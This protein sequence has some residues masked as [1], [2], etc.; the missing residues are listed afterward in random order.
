MLCRKLYCFVDC[1]FV[2]LGHGVP[3][4]CFCNIFSQGV[5]IGNIFNL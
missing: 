3:L 5:D 1:V 4:G 2:G